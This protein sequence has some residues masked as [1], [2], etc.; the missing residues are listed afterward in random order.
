MT[1]ALSCSLWSSMYECQRVECAFTSPV[2]TECGN[3]C[4]VLCAVLYVRVN[5]F[6]VRV[7]ALS[8]RYINVCNSDEFSVVYID[9]LKLCVVCINGRMYVRCGECYAVPDECDEPTPCLVRPTGAHGGEV[10]YLGSFYFKDE[11]GFLNC[12]DICMCVVNRQFELLEIVFNSVYVDLKYN[13]ISL[14]F[15]A[16]SVCLCG[17][18][19]HVLVIGLSVRLSFF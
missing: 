18:C 11:L 2:R 19:S 7:Y 13:E 1:S 4:D 5:C 10:M 15:T 14:T 6:V 8:R 3:V 9:H 12:D 17:V 16:G